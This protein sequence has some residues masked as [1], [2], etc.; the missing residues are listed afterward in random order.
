MGLYSPNRSGQ[1]VYASQ[2]R[3]RAACHSGGGLGLLR[4]NTGLLVFLEQQPSAH[5]GHLRP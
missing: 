1:A 4:R 2:P 5:N 3:A